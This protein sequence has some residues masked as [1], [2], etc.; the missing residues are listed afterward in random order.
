MTAAW[1][2]PERVGYFI[3]KAII[4]GLLIAAVSTLARRSPALGA[5]V[6]SLPLVSLLG[7]LWLWHDTHDPVRMRAHVGATF[8]YVLPSLP[9]FLLIPAL[10]RAGVW[11]YPALAAG[12]LV[13]VG[14]YLFMIRLG[15]YLGLTL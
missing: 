6:A 8:W 4:S 1:C 7:M 12:C 3:V 11:F 13:T 10:M 2:G 9:M 5:L 15:P 14:L